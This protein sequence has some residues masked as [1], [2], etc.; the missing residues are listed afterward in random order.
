V[1]GSGKLPVDAVPLP[2]DHGRPDMLDE[3]R[4]LFA[5]NRWANLRL[6]DAVAPLTD[7][8]LGRDL[9]GS[10]PNVAAVLVHLLGAEWVWL[11]RWQGEAPASFPDV[12]QL[13]SV[14]AVRARWDALWEEQQTYLA[15]LDE[16]ALGYDVA[17]KTFD[18]TPYRQPLHELIRHVVNHATYHRGQLAAMLRQ[19]GRTP[20]STDLVRFYREQRS[21]G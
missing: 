18:G 12:A 10:F 1:P 16:A 8:E 4:T 14:A 17:Y 3:L 11:R 5:Y 13:T 2:A 9:G 7:A 20:P 6:L 21:A 19:L 15:G